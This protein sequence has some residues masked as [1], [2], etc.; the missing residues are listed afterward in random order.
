[1]AAGFFD[2]ELYDFKEQYEAHMYKDVQLKLQSEANLRIIPHVR[3]HLIELLKKRRL[4]VTTSGLLALVPAQVRPGDVIAVLVGGVVPFVL[5]KKE[6]TCSEIPSG[7][8]QAVGT[9]FL[10]VSSGDRK[11]G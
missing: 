11:R 8:S 10:A 6:K 1:M 9:E 5:R 2:A 3:K 4:T 7:D